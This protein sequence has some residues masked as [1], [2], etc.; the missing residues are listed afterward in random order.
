MKRQSKGMIC[1]RY[2]GDGYSIEYAQQYGRSLDFDTSSGGWCKKCVRLIRESERVG[3]LL[4]CM[5]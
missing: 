3:H 2:C 4:P 1:G 5:K